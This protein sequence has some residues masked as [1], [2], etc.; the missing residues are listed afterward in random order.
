MLITTLLTF[1]GTR[2][3]V[4]TKAD[5]PTGSL[6][7]TYRVVFSN[8]PFVLLLLTYAFHIMALTFLQSILVYY[9]RYVYSADLTTIA[10]LVLLLVAM[11][12]IPISVLVSKRIGKKRTYQI[13][14]VIIASACLIIFTLGHILGPKFFMSMMVYAGI[15][16]G[17]SYVA[18]YA[19]IPDAID[20]D[21]LKTG[22]RHEGAYYGM[23]TFIS[24]LGTALSVFLSGLILSLG[25][26]IADT[27]QSPKT[28]LAIRL[29]IGPIPGVIF[30]A[31]LAVIQ[32]YPLDEK[33]CRGIRQETL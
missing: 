14:F 5:L 27:V 25:G 26:Y 23:W 13:C 21:A 2:E 6:L 20:F 31:A 24:K 3:R 4:H 19:M 33:S 18:P 11:V 8:K 15:G 17:F 1:F 30:I 28:I 12:F 29:L 32:R 22:E 7:A 9:T 16:V 10:M